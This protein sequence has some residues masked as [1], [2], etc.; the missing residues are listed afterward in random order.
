MASTMTDATTIGLS[1]ALR[2]LGEEDLAAVLRN[3]PEAAAAA[4]SGADLGTIA[5][6]LARPDAVWNA[7]TRLDEFRFHVLI[8]A[9]W[10]GPEVPVSEVRQQAPGVTDDELA[11]AVRSLEQHALLFPRPAK[12]GTSLWVPSCVADVVEH[13]GDPGLHVKSLL[14]HDTVRD[15][16]EMAVRLGISWKE[17]PGK[18]GLLDLVA[19]QLA[20]PDAVEALVRG[21]SDVARR[22]LELIRKVGGRAS[23][24]ELSKFGL[25]D[26]RDFSYEYRIEN[27]TALAWL[28][29]RGL[30]LPLH[31]WDAGPTMEF[32]VPGEVECALR[33]GAVFAEWR[34]TPPH[35]GVGAG[36]PSPERGPEEVLSDAE[37]LLHEWSVAPATRL[38]AGGLGKRE[39][40]K[41]ADRTGIDERLVSFLYAVLVEAGLLCYEADKVTASGAAQRWLEQPPAARWAL[42]F[43]TWRRL[44]LWS[45]SDGGLVPLSTR[46]FIDHSHIRT[47]VLDALLRLKPDEAIDAASLG[48]LLAW[49]AP[50]LF[51][52]ESGAAKLAPRVIDGLVWLGTARAAPAV[53]LFDPAR[54]ILVDPEWAKR[55]GESDRIFTAPVAEC[56]VQAD[57]TV[58]VPGRP[59]AEL[60]RGLARFCEVEASSPAA[61]YRIAEDSVRRGL[62]LGMRGDDM[63]ALL[64]RYASKGVPQPVAYLIEDTARRHGRVRVGAGGA[65]VR[66]DDPGL[67]AEVVGDRRIKKLDPR[68]LAPTVAVVNERSP[69]L[70]LKALRDAGYMPVTEEGGA[71]VTKPAANQSPIIRRGDADEPPAPS[72]EKASELAAALLS[73]RPRAVT[74]ER[75]V[76]GTAAILRVL[77]KMER[78][79]GRV[80]IGYRHTD[81]LSVHVVEPLSVRKKKLIG[82]TGDNDELTSLTVARIEWV[83]PIDDGG[84]DVT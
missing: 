74:D 12:E 59:V 72:P 70:V 55:E 51:Y 25:A 57:L 61:V 69:A 34:P 10:F 44:L 15:L 38:K 79:G 17:F 22:T 84:V 16:V 76:R 45:E 48:A 43:N 19:A 18:D 40:R 5:G 27:E 78:T 33:G 58:I 21:A 3:R 65:Y 11:G 32:V 54:S 31:R 56:T 46:P 81:G 71:V 2:A 37:A 7:V 77:R 62:D 23:W 42:L 35:V 80:E 29:D 20:T 6:V 63:L 41:A 14:E 13:L 52:N 24:T 9:A 49:S 50:G 36:A 39:L 53:Q 47:A 1:D 68:L 67:L 82:W 60:G 4:S 30:V 26:Y 64:E 75:A 28:G 66:S 73:G 83:R 8:A